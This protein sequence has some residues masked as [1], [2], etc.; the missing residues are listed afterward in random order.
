MEDVEADKL[1]LSTLAMHLPVR[2]QLNT[3]GYEQARRA[4]SLHERDH[5]NTLHTA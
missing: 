1:A 3:I 5:L 2:Q 4:L